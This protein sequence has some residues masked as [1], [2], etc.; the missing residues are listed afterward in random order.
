[1]TGNE[2]GD[3]VYK[4]FYTLGENKENDFAGSL[5]LASLDAKLIKERNELHVKF[6]WLQM[7]KTI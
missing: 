1:V 5:L 4:I 6:D 2:L 7:R 3:R